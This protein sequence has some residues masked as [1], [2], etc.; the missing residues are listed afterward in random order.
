MANKPKDVKVV[1]TGI[2]DDF[3]VCVMGIN[4]IIEFSKASKKYKKVLKVNN[5]VKRDA[6]STDLHKGMSISLENNQQID[7]QKL[8]DFKE[9]KAELEN[10]NKQQQE[11]YGKAE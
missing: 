4:N 8:I 7:I 6:L 10:R 3:E 9:R 11:G 5:A 1:P 2:N